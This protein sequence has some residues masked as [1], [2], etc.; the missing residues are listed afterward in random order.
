MMRNENIPDSSFFAFCKVGAYGAEP[1]KISL[2]TNVLLV[3]KKMYITT[4]TGYTITVKEIRQHKNNTIRQ[5][6]FTYLIHVRKEIFAI[7]TRFFTAS[8]KYLLSNTYF[9]FY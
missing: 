1:T 3:C 5:Q 9:F 8:T 7:D 2:I 6:T 4:K